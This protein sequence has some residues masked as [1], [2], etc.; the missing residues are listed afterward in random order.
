MATSRTLKE[1]T[2]AEIQAA[3]SKAMTELAGREYIVVLNG[4]QFEHTTTRAFLGTE[5]ASFSGQVESKREYSGEDP[6]KTE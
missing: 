3:F 5:L 1:I 6:F 2:L 4:L